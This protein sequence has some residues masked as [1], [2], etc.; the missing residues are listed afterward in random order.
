MKKLNYLNV[1]MSLA[2]LFALSSCSKNGDKSL[3]QNTA[4]KTE[5]TDMMSEQGSNP[6]EASVT[7]N[8][9]TDGT[10]LNRGTNESNG[11]YL[12]TVGNG[13]EK[14]YIIS[15][16]I[17]SNGMLQSNGA[18]ASGGTGTGKGLG[19]QGALVLSKNHEWLFA[20]N[21]GSNT[22]SSFKVKDDGTLMLAHTE[23]TM[24]K[25][26]VSVSVH[27]N[28]LYVLN[29][30]SDNIHGFW[31]GAGGSLSHIAGSTQD[32]SSKMVDAPQISITPGGDWVV[33][34]EKATNIIGTFKLKNN[35]SVSAGKF[36][37]SVG[38]TPFGFDYS[39]NRFMIV[40]NAAGGAAG[41]GSSTSYI[42][43]N[44]GK[45]DAVNGAVNSNQAA[46]CWVATTK[47]GR[48]AFVTNTASNNV[49]SYYVAPWGA[50]YLIAGEAAKTDMG[51]LDIVVAANN[52]YVYIL[53]GKSNSI[54]EYKRKFFGG[55]EHI[56]TLANVPI[57][58]VG[59]A[60]F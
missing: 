4:S 55:L 45:P 42:I 28:L 7:E 14:N 58:A 21:A 48:Y 44:N 51:P 13:P 6:D 35:G 38:P 54:S 32:L 49:S 8:T 18:T 37:T 5:L 20:V 16:E 43:G 25:E 22:V 59:L 24:G 12:Y 1:V 27:D 53:N 26:P 39:R 11:H 56:G 60:T 31:I 50:L 36:T 17:K 15:Y 34:T 40:S 29:R 57:S 3:A 47:Y 19:S 41:A 10:V 23:S 33:V 2:I 30:G 52:Y 9:G 46:P